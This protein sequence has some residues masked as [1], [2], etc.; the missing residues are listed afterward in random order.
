MRP[1][2]SLASRNCETKLPCSGLNWGHFVTKPV[3]TE[4]HLTTSLQK[5]LPHCTVP[6]L[7]ACT[8]DPKSS[9]WGFDHANANAFYFYSSE[10]TRSQRRLPDHDDS[11][12]FFQ[13]TRKVP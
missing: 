6:L 8:S 13:I 12:D 1:T 9:N 5:L 2:V 4:A 7:A 3:P 11:S 10:Q